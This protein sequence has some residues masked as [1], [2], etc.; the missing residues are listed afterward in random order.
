M[1]GEGGARVQALRA[2]PASGRGVGLTSDTGL[3]WT[4]KEK[5]P[6]VTLP[7][8]CYRCGHGSPDAVTEAGPRRAFQ[9]AC[10]REGTVSG[11]VE[12]VEKRVQ[13]HPHAIHLTWNLE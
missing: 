13:G 2:R 8:H 9:L 11:G 7:G 6:R 5:K 12:P 1:S 10:H 4:K 3:K